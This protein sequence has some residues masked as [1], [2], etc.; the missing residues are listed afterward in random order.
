MTIPDPTRPDA[1]VVVAG[2]KLT[3]PVVVTGVTLREAS[4]D[5]RWLV[6]VAHEVLRVARRSSCEFPAPIGRKA[7]SGAGAELYDAEELTRWFRDWS[8][9]HR[10]VGRTE[11]EAREWA[12]CSGGGGAGVPASPPPGSAGGDR[13]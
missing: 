1:D 12:A 13:S 9:A 2:G 4:R 7:G 10:V 3:S 5:G 8:R 11:V 6:P